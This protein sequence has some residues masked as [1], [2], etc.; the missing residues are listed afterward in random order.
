MYKLSK[1]KYNHLLQNSITKTYKKAE[2][3]VNDKINEDGKKIAEKM[4]ILNR[5]DINGTNDCFIT[6]KDHKENFENNLPTRLINPAK[7]EVGRISKVIVQNLNDK[8]HVKLKMQ[9]W[10]N[11]ADVINWFTKI[12]NKHAY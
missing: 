7:N 6:L 4:N 10:K 3:H 1:E 12:E 9:Q 11:T 2:K 8:L 5:M